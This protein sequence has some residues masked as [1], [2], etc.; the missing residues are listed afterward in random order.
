VE[1]EGLRQAFQ[2]PHT[3][4]AFC[5]LGSVKGNFGHLLAAAG[6]AGL[7]KA[8]L[9]VEHGLVPPT[10]NFETANPGV[11]L[12]RSPF[13]INREPVPFPARGELR[14]A[15]VSSF[16][17][18][19]TNA[20]VVVEQAPAPADA[21]CP[22]RPELLVLSARSES[23]LARHVA[24]TGKHLGARPDSCMADVTYTLQAGRRAFPHRF[25]SVVGDAVSAAAALRDPQPHSSG[26]AQFRGEAPQVL[27]L[28]PGVGSQRDGMGAGWYVND[29]TYRGAV[30]QC[31]LRLAGLGLAEPPGTEAGSGD[32][33][34][35]RFGS[36]GVD[37]DLLTLFV[38]DYALAQTWIAWGVRPRAVLG[39]SLGE[40][41]AACV[42]GVLSLD[43]ALRY[44][45]RLAELALEAPEGRMLA[46]RLGE[47]ELEPHL[48]G[49]D[50][51]EI[52]ADNSPALSLASG[53]V[54]SIEALSSRL[55]SEGVPQ[56]ILPGR[57]AF[58]TAAFD[59]VTEALWDI[60]DRLDYGRPKI[61]WVSSVTGRLV[62][63]HTA[64]D[65]S[66]WARHPRAKVRFREA[67]ATALA[68]GADLALET[69]PGSS[70]GTC[71]RQVAGRDGP[72]VVN[73][74]SDE[75]AGP[76][77]EWSGALAAV[78][79]CWLAGCDIDWPALH[80]G[81]RRRVCLPTYPFERTRHWL[82]T[83]AATERA[84][85]ALEV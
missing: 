73:T 9:A 40:L 4:E 64:S 16:G 53:P 39:H 82:P 71:V 54:D 29:A 55:E 41:V 43:D 76:E 56:R 23:A 44:L 26:T 68:S 58:H 33:E 35:P 17:I 45:G 12:S 5:A 42:S 61:P 6:V 69:G 27:F 67:V 3:G 81:A 34:P 62:D 25:F 65:P 77:S 60:A 49:F 85:P 37:T 31:A 10:V 80:R 63:M 47:T 19:G 83:R 48:R 11:D 51:V 38:T 50:G 24:Q 2:Y 52:A 72:R 28:F 75:G 21:D 7:I 59:P 36:G 70:L 18:G 30:D 79:R 13:F 78:G 22:D 1:V 15:G 57:R 32:P 66:Y 8:V 74:L 84:S 14:R 20:H 46:V